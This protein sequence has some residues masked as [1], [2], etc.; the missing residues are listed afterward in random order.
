MSFSRKLL[1]PFD[2]FEP[3][4]F[5]MQF[6]V[7][8]IMHVIIQNKQFCR[9][10]AYKQRTDQSVYST[11]KHLLLCCLSTC[12]LFY[13]ILDIVMI[14]FQFYY[15]RIHNIIYILLVHEINV[16]LLPTTVYIL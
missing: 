10:M 13:Q 16:I 15:N 2:Y 5:W 1:G 9:I 14:V 3:I 4:K 8:T 7:R 6:P 12:N 11:V